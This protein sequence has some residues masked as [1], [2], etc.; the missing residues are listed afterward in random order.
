LRTLHARLQEAGRTD[1]ALLA[2][3]DAS[4]AAEEV[5]AYAQAEGLPF[6]IGLASETGKAGG[7]TPAFQAYGVRRLPTVFLIDAAGVVQAVDP[8]REVLMRLA[9]GS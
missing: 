2:I 1:V 9:G 5:V 6:P 7:E 8:P 4:A 3:Y